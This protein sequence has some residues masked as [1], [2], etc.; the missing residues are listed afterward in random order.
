MDVLQQHRFSP[1]RGLKRA[2]MT[3]GSILVRVNQ[4]DGYCVRIRVRVKVRVP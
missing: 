3:R 2:V 4:I 1:K